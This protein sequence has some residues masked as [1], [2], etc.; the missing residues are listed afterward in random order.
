[1]GKK[2]IKFTDK[3]SGVSH[4]ILSSALGHHVFDVTK[5]VNEMNATVRWCNS[6]GV[7]DVLDN[8]K[9]AVEIISVS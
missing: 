2:T 1:M 5:S 4:E 7:G 8:D 6:H 9:F 3:K